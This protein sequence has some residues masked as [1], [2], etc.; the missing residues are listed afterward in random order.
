MPNPD[1]C[2]ARRRTRAGSS[3][4]VVLTATLF[5][6]A[7]ASAGVATRGPQGIVP[8]SAGERAQL[9]LSNWT[10]PNG[11]ACVLEEQPTQL[12]RPMDLV[13]VAQ[14]YVD[15]VSARSAIGEVTGHVL[16]SIGY[17]GTGR[18]DRFHVVESSITDSL[19]VR[20]IANLV[21]QRLFR[22]TPGAP[23]GVRLRVTVDE[24]PAV[25]VGRREN[26]FPRWADS[27]VI[28]SVDRD[29]LADEATVPSNRQVAF[30]LFADVDGTVQDVYVQSRPARVINTGEMLNA[31]RSTVVDMPALLDRQ[32]VGFW[33]TV[34]EDINAR[35]QLP[36][37]RMA[38]FDA[39]C[40]TN[41]YWY[42][43]MGCGIDNRYASFG[44]RYGYGNGFGYGSGWGGFGYG[45]PII[46]VPPPTT[47]PP[48]PQPP[49]ADTSNGGEGQPMDPDA[50]FI[51]PIR[52]DP[53][54]LRPDPDG[55]TPEDAAPIRSG[56][57]APRA[58][59]APARGVLPGREADGR[60]RRAAE[61]RRA[62][63]LRAE[64]P[65]R[66]DRLGALPSAPASTNAFRGRGTP[67]W[68]TN[69]DTPDAIRTRAMTPRQTRAGQL[70][71]ADVDRRMAPAP[72]PT[73]PRLRPAPSGMRSTPHQRG[74]G[75]DT[76]GPDVRGNGS[77]EPPRSAPAPRAQPAPSAPRPAP[78]RGGGSEPPLR[79]VG[80]EQPPS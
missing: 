31:A 15:L 4:A 50:P 9:T 71:P 36:I 68:G 44:N 32:P 59:P 66:A 8:R 25:E 54:A 65:Q 42:G 5:L 47:P 39:G 41:Y 73:S 45:F 43:G 52:V 60:W 30:R 21:D 19:L 20:D 12:P 78:V 16:L 48:A 1:P 18:P 70:R 77:A 35:G 26:C 51:P 75:R 76:R 38:A 53:P 64:A 29:P 37:G 58:R 63:E 79:R 14:L 2:T 11:Y 22:Q 10:P 62:L 69:R 46:I 23:F 49:P 6:G 13:D 27:P 57:D 80:A 28:G 40:F 72:S 17:N 24:M 55:V 7:C 61:Q 3:A 33:F 67:T 34:R 56:V 74:D